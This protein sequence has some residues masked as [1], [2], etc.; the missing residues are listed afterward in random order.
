MHRSRF[1]LMVLIALSAAGCARS[2]QAYMIDPEQPAPVAYRQQASQPQYVQASYPAPQ[3]AAIGE[4]GLF[5]S[6]H[7]AQQQPTA[8]LAPSGERGL[9]TAQPPVYLQQPAQ[10]SYA[11]Q[12]PAPQY[13]VPRTGGLYAAPPN[14]FAAAS[15]Y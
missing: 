10:P 12:T 13:A 3:A 9:F 11:M 2:Q 7:S 15:L 5:N 8:Q 14:S 6:W 4:R 1:Y